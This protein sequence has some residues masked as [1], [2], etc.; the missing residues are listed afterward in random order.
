MS[1]YEVSFQ[2]DNSEVQINALF[3]QVV[4]LQAEQ[5]AIIDT[6]LESRYSAALAEQIEDK[7]E[8]VE[9]IEERLDDLIELQA[10]RLKQAQSNEPGL[11]ALP[12]SRLK[13]QQQ[14]QRLQGAMQ[15]LNSR[16]EVVREIKDG[17]GIHAPRIEEMA[18]RKLQH[19]EPDLV[20]QWEDMQ[21]EQ[22]RQ[23]IMSRKKIDQVLVGKQK[24]GAGLVLSIS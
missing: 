14:M 6:Q 1:D 10:S 23:Q 18:H 5:V 19:K 3:E 12:G 15:R 20:G 16:V 21:A 2:S 7:Y 4:E 22:R 24:Q 13:W 17:M 8:Q 9:H 11:L